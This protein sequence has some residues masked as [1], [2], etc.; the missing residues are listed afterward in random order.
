MQGDFPAMIFTRYFAVRPK[1]ELLEAVSRSNLDVSPL[2]PEL[3]KRNSSD[4]RRT[5]EADDVALLKSN[6]LRIFLDD[7]LGSNYADHSVLLRQLDSHEFD[8]L[9]TLEVFSGCDDI[10]DAISSLK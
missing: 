4:R 9:W 1:P 8:A 3:L 10:D 2:R 6:Y 5:T 7:L